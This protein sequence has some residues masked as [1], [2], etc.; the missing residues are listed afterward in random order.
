MQLAQPSRSREAPTRRPQQ[1][2]LSPLG[3]RHDVGSFEVAAQCFGGKAKVAG[4]SASSSL[5]VG[6]SSAAREPSVGGQA[7]LLSVCVVFLLFAGSASS[8]TVTFRDLGV[9]ASES[10]RHDPN[11]FF[12][13][14]SNVKFVFPKE[15]VG[16]HN[17]VRIKNLRLSQAS[18]AEIEQ[19]RA[20]DLLARLAPSS[21]AQKAL[22]DVSPA[23]IEVVLIKYRQLRRMLTE[24]APFPF[25]CHGMPFSP[26]K[27]FVPTAECPYPNAMRRIFW[28]RR[29]TYQLQEPQQTPSPEQHDSILQYDGE[30]IYVRPVALAGSADAEK[31]FTF[32]VRDSDIYFLVTANCGPLSDLTFEGEISVSNAYGKLPGYEYSGFLCDLACVVAYA[33]LSLVWGV[34]LLRQKKNLIPFHYCL[35]GVCLLGLLESAAELASLY[36]WNFYEPSRPLICLSIALCVLK[37]ISA[38]VLV[39]LGAIGWS[40]TRP[41]LDRPTRGGGENG[42]GEGRQE[43]HEC[44]STPTSSSPSVAAGSALASLQLSNAY[45]NSGTFSLLRSLIVLLPISVLNVVVFYWIFSALHD[46]IEGS[47]EP[48]LSILLDIRAAQAASMHACAPHIAIR[49]MPCA[50]A[51]FPLLMMPLLRYWLR[52]IPERARVCCDG[53]LCSCLPER[54]STRSSSSTDVSFVFC[55]VDSFLPREFWCSNSTLQLSLAYF[56]EIGDSEEVEMPRQQQRAKRGGTGAQVWG[57][58]L[59]F[60]DHF[61][62]EDF[63]EDAGSRLRLES[64]IPTFASIQ[65]GG[66]GGGVAGEGVGQQKGGDRSLVP[67]NGVGV[68]CTAAQVASAA[69]RDQRGQG[70]TAIE[71][72][73]NRFVV[74]LP[75]PQ[76]AISTTEEGLQAQVIGRPTFVP[77][78]EEGVEAGELPRT[79]PPFAPSKSEA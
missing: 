33:V 27:P 26:E 76:E 50:S 58:E 17:V 64:N 5:S 46:N 68:A 51:F 36:I 8:Q 47:V 19:M 25:C 72:G 13:Y 65:V 21:S 23:G 11:A 63:E 44:S 73:T 10:L 53:A 57:D 31:E 29:P 15:A 48:A 41:S 6:R 38:Y 56:T 22:L 3:P 39:L 12:I 2:L 7:L 40:I 18:S 14:G 49:W 43:V 69:C 45:D 60:H 75:T 67:A 59:D 30:E 20:Q 54:N 34:C 42:G 77:S 28:S 79:E 62:D 61:S 1:P 35:G 78:S 74:G 66:P 16:K 70:D 4:R 32:A 24:P 55:L 71:L 52:A 37:N 9:P